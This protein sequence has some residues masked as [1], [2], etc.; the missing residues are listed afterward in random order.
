MFHK[1][2]Y[3][4]FKLSVKFNRF[5]NYYMDTYFVNGSQQHKTPYEGHHRNQQV[6]MNPKL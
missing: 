2:A 3:F 1:Q 6:H 4:S 5:K